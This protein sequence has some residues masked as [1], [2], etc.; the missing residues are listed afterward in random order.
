MCIVKE[1]KKGIDKMKEHNINL[2]D[3]GIKAQEQMRKEKEFIAGVKQAM[4]F[5]TEVKTYN[6]TY[7][8]C[9]QYINQKITIASINAIDN[10]AYIGMIALYSAMIDIL[11]YLARKEK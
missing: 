6:G 5:L 2:I 9:I 11:A 3:L 4:E 8:D 7:L 10:N 1:L